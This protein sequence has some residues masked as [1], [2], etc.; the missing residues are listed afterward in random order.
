M[1]E[2]GA[3]AERERRMRDLLARTD[4]SLRAAVEAERNAIAQ[5]G[6][7]QWQADFLRFAGR[8]ADAD[9]A[10]QRA[11][12]IDPDDWSPKL[13]YATA[14]AA[15]RGRLV[16]AADLIESAGGPRD[17]RTQD[18]VAAAAYA[19]WAKAYRARPRASESARLLADARKEH[20]GVEAVFQHVSAYES[21][22]DVAEAM[23]DAGVYRVQRAEYRD[24][25]GDTA[26]ANLILNFGYVAGNESRTL[27][28]PGQAMADR[29]LGQGA[30]P[31]AWASRTREPV[32]SVAARMGDA[33][34]VDRLLRAGASV[35]ERGAEG[36][37][38]IAAA[39]QAADPK[40]AL[41]LVQR[42][43]GKG[44]STDA[45]ADNGTTVLMAAAEAGHDEVVAWLLVRGADPHRVDHEGA[46]VLDR[47]AAA[48]NQALVERLLKAGVAQTRIVGTCGVITTQ[49]RA[50]H[51]PAIVALLKQYEKRAI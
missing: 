46:N 19:R 9:Q 7:L 4:Q 8:N 29:L 28:K 48:G 31:N 21:T 39:T 35:H 11:A 16:E 22:V 43:A 32:V 10:L 3:A 41:E 44:A 50:R 27:P 45:R 24:R 25:D 5:S 17:E 23:L 40:V 49:A 20:P 34:L 13:R 38:P 12:R 37:T 18:I 42:M 14:I 26:L 15:T 51:H 36:G 47:A 33:W 30:N 1:R 6:Y 2:P